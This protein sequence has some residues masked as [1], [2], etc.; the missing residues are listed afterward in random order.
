[1]LMTLQDQRVGGRF[2]MN[3]VI[4]KMIVVE[5]V[6]KTAHKLSSIFIY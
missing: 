2:H 1:M 5:R 6:V 4:F 3:A